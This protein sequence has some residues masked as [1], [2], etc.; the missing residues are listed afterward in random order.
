MH[1]SPGSPVSGFNPE[2]ISRDTISLPDSSAPRIIPATGSL[3]SPL[4]L[5]PRRARA[6]KIGHEQ[7]CQVPSS[8]LHHLNDID[9]ELILA[10][11]STVAISLAERYCMFEAN[12]IELLSLCT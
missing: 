2:G 4:I 11:S 10:N 1:G 5:Y 9:V 12:Y 7:L 3:G 6:L 8:V